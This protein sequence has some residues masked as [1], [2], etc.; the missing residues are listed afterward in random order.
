[1]NSEIIALIF[2]T[3]SLF[4]LGG[5]VLRKIPVLID[6]PDTLPKEKE[7]L[8]L[9]L[10][11]FCSEKN[12][13]KNFCYE[14]FLQKILAKIRIFTLKIENLTLAWHQ[15]LKKR[16]QKKNGERKDG[17]WEEVKKGKE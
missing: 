8:S 11:R 2:F 5:I 3:G 1:M 15:E 14:I 17:Y 16:Y 13:L 9:R 12:P 10:K 6:L 7:K 4:G